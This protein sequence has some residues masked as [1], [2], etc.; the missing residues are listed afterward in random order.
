MTRLNLTGTNFG[1]LTV[2]AFLGSRG[3]NG[4]W[5][6]ACDCGGT[7]EVSTVHLRRGHTQSCGCLQR[8]ITSRVQGTH[9]ESVHSGLSK[10]YNAWVRMKQRC[11]NPKAPRFERWGGRG[12]TVCDRWRNSFENFLAD[13]GR[14]PPGTSL[15]REDNDG[16][17]EP[18]NCRWATPKEQAA[19]RGGRFTA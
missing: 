14:S 12:I 11:F 6:C 13:M 10:E 3:G 17:Y 4:Y 19:N 8:E 5:S 1:R 7:A 15:D 2:G 16:N 9:R 18:G